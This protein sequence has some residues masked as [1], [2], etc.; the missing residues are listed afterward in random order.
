MFDTVMRRVKEAVFVP[1]ARP[2]RHLPP[3]LF[4]LISL[5]LGLAAAA[6]LWRQTYGIG[7]VLWFFNRVFDALDGTIARLGNSQS[8]FGGYLDILI[9]FAVYAAIPIGLA[10]GRP[11]MNT[12]LY[13]ILLLAIFYVNGASW[14]YL[15]AILEKRTAVAD[16][17]ETSVHMPE[18]IIGGTETILFYTAFILFPGWLDWL[19]GLMAGL[20]ALTIIQRLVWAGRHLHG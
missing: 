10:L 5:V 4:S 6:A 16:A 8:D 14:M 7:L 3:W 18:G 11:E 15:A 9:D 20:T 13:L 1:L 17:Y 2:L 19:F 12:Y